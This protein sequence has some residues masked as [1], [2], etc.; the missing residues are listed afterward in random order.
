M[1][2]DWS[3]PTAISTPSGSSSRNLL[4]PGSDGPGDLDGVG[5]A[6]LVDRQL[7]RLVAAE[8]GDHLALLVAA[9]DDRR[10]RRP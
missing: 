5:V 2:R 7:D 6:L 8:A 3:A 1:N 4:E 9:G 10:R